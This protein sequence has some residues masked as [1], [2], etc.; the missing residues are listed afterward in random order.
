[1]SLGGQP[2]HRSS[3]PGRCQDFVCLAYSGRYDEELPSNVYQALSSPKIR[4][5]LASSPCSTI[6]PSTVFMPADLSQNG[7]LPVPC[8]QYQFEGAIVALPFMMA[9]AP[10]MCRITNKIKVVR[11]AGID[12]FFTT[13]QNDVCLTW[14]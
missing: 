4:E 13:F 11:G 9:P 8:M 5:A 6:R 10:V 7:V 3:L 1:M 14:V 2:T 12:Q